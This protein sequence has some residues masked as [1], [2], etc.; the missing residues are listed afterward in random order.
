MYSMDTLF[1]GRTCTLIGEVLIAVMVLWV[2]HKVEKDK[3][4]DKG[5]IRTLRQ[6]WF[7]ALLGVMFLFIGYILEI[8]S[9]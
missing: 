2:H 1:L 4:I 9:V 6:E 3:K 8:I 5:V 7:I